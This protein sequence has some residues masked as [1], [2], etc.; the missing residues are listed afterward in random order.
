M[1][2]QNT[3]MT[4]IT[5]I[6]E[7]STRRLLAAKRPDYLWE[8]VCFTYLAKQDWTICDVCRICFFALISFICVFIVFEAFNKKRS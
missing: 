2:M 3:S 1:L 8:T 4:T 7:E 6:W 5:G